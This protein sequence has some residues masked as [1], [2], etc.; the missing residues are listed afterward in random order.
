[1]IKYENGS[2]DG[3]AKP[4]HRNDQTTPDFY[5]SFADGIQCETNESINRSDRFEP[6]EDPVLID[7]VINLD[8][9]QSNRIADREVVVAGIIDP[10]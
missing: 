4:S 8:D 5:L 7:R 10:R 2:A 3:S 9:L 6:I 1:M